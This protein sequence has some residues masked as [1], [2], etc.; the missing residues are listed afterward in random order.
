MEAILQ[1]KFEFGGKSTIATTKLCLETSEK[2][3]YLIVANDNV[4]EII[5]VPVVESKFDSG[6]SVQ[7][8]RN[9]LTPLVLSLDE[10]VMC[11]SLSCS[12]RFLAV[13]MQSRLLLLDFHGILMD[14]RYE[15]TKHCIQHFEF[16]YRSLP[17]D[18]IL[19]WY[20]SSSRGVNHSHSS[21]NDG[22]DDL[23]LVS[24]NN[25]ELCLV[26]GIKGFVKRISD[27]KYT[28]FSWSPPTSALT[29]R[30]S[31]QQSQQLI[32]AAATSNRIDILDITSG[33]V[34]CTVDDVLETGDV[35]VSCEITHV[36]WFRPDKVFVGG[37]TRSADLELLVDV[38][39]LSVSFGDTVTVS[40]VKKNVITDMV[41]PHD[42][43]NVDI[44]LR[45]RY[46]EQW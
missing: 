23:L 5:S 42:R 39:Q 32:G 9:D 6:D 12:E 2:Y 46:I 27:T 36:H 37:H 41:C 24:G 34:I 31:Q 4:I 29:S 8:L 26:S 3:G 44:V 1:G 25:D 40:N 28:S 45:S 7:S 15:P 17:Y 33:Q 14:K 43:Q 10:T 20:P 22:S 21:N 18:P 13:F 30:E 35:N 16:P 19:S 38:V 11:M